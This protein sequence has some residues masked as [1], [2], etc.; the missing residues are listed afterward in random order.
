[1]KENETLYVPIP[2]E[3]ETY[4]DM[5]K[6]GKLKFRR[7]ARYLK[8]TDGNILIESGGDIIYSMISGKTCVNLIQHISKTKLMR[9]DIQRSTEINIAYDEENSVECPKEEFD[10]MYEKA[11]LIINQDVRNNGEVL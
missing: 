10:R 3:F 9:I 6:A 11:I 7:E 4:E 1:M 5:I 2:D 8:T